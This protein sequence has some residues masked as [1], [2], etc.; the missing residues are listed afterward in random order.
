MIPL[1]QLW[2]PTMRQVLNSEA[3][4]HS[5]SPLSPAFASDLNALIRE[6]GIPLWIHC[7]THYNVGPSNRFGT[8][9]VTNQRGYPNEPC[10]GFDPEMVI[11]L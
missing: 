11:E 5:T 10:M 7:H 8:R 1:E 4:Y 6:S 2:S 3:P 9:V